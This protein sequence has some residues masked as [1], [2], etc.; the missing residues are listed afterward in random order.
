MARVGERGTEQKLIT[1]A[2]AVTMLVGVMSPQ[3]WLRD[4]PPSLLVLLVK[5]NVPQTGRRLHIASPPTWV[6]A[7]LWSWKRFWAGLDH[8]SMFRCRRLVVL[9]ASSPMN[10]ITSSGRPVLYASWQDKKKIT[11]ANIVMS[12]HRRLGQGF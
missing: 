1:L 12:N 2:P 10:V 4:S 9:F 7:V 8:A 11:C 6:S 5:T 3:R